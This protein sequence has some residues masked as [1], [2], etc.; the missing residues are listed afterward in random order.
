MMNVLW[1]K[2]DRISVEFLW[3]SITRSPS[4]RQNTKIEPTPSSTT[5][6]APS[7]AG[8]AAHTVAAPK[9]LRVYVTTSI[10]R[11]RRE[12]T[13]F[14][15]MLFPRNLAY[16]REVADGTWPHAFGIGLHGIVSG[17]SVLYGVET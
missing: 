16:V 13:H 11:P 17:K 1:T 15:T 9:S 8:T 4:L 10:I 6:R 7:A 2:A 12:E 14:S 3:I 5:D